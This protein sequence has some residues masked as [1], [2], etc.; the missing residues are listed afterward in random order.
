MKAATFEEAFHKICSKY[1]KKYSQF[2][3]IAHYLWFNHRDEYSWHLVDWRQ[4]RHPAFSKL[5]TDREEV[6]KMNRPIES[7]MKHYY[8]FEF[9]DY[10]FKLIGDYY[11]LVTIILTFI[12]IMC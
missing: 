1:L 8:H 6:L 4:T 2:D 3:L 9:P 12:L 5:M 11:G 10:A 7:L